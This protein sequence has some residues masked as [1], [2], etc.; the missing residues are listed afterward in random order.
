MT[1]Q[2][3]QVIFDVRASLPVNPEPP[4]PKGKGRGKGKGKK[5]C[6]GRRLDGSAFH[7]HR[8][9]EA[10]MF[11]CLDVCLCVC[12]SVCACASSCVLAQDIANEDFDLLMRDLLEVLH[13]TMCQ[14]RHGQVAMFLN[15][16]RGLHRPCLRSDVFALWVCIAWL[17]LC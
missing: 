9:C 13:Q 11:K 1:K 4:A 14:A 7:D 3:E 17:C 8:R 12:V 5:S 15:C 16:T 6:T 2:F 10:C